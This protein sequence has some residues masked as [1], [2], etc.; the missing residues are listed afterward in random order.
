MKR[1]VQAVCAAVAIWS[2]NTVYAAENGINYDPAHDQPWFDA[3]QSNDTS[4]MYTLLLQD[5]AQIKA[6]GFGTIKTYYSLYCSIN[7]N[8]TPSIAGAAKNQGLKLLVGVYEFRMPEDNCEPWCLSGTEQQVKA[9]IAHAREHPDVVIGIVVGN[10]DM[11]DWQGNPRPDMQKRIVQDIKTIQDQVSV[12]VT[13]AQRQGDWC[14]GP[15]PGC[16]PKRTNSLNLSDPYGVLNTVQ[17]IG[18]NIFPYWGGSP[19]NVGGQSV[20]SK[21]QTTAGHLKQA[22][23]KNVIVTEEGWPSCASNTQNPTSISD[24]IDYFQTWSKHENQTVDSYYFM[25]YDINIGCQEGFKDADKH[26][27][28]CATNGVTKDPRLIACPARITLPVRA[29]Q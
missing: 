22:L 14:G 10:E 3:Q 24:E 4:M 2:F 27:G 21:T 16:D 15:Q 11:F 5:L 19:E 6:M 1:F 28:L 25:A 7:G 9:A 18:A 20:A 13:T 12:P 8:C 23:G 26:F 29:G 17:I